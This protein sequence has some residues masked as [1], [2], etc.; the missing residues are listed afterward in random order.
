MAAELAR[1]SGFR[2]SARMALFT[3]TAI[4][5]VNYLDRYLVAGIVDPLKGEFDVG[6]A[7]I[8]LLT[9]VFLGVYMVAAPIFG[10]L[11]R[12]GS[13]TIWL[14]F[15]ILV[16]SIATIA[17]GLA[18]SFTQLLIARAVVGIGEAAYTAIGPALLSDHY[19]PVKRPVVL[20]IFYAAI[21]VG[22]ALSYIVAGLVSEAWGWRAVFF[23][24]GVPGLLLGTLC[25]FLVD[26]PR[27]QCDEGAPRS[28]T[29]TT[30]LISSVRAL[31]NNAAFLV[32][33]AGY[34][35]FTF[36]FGALAVWMPNYLESTRGWTRAD[37]TVTFGIVLVCSGI[38]GTLGGGLLVRRFGSGRRA[39]LALCALFLLIAAPA[40]AVSL[41]STQAWLVIT[42]LAIASTFSFA[43]QGPVNAVIVNAVDAQLR[44]LAVGLS[45]L[46]IHLFGDVP[47]PWLVGVISDSGAGMERAMSLIPLAMVVALLIWAIGVRKK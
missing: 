34:A 39:S 35:A 42:A 10:V 46:T 3:L 21:P 11:A 47:S 12:R 27:G 24:G 37:S 4:N 9:S 32:T 38:V 8:G 13:R 25:L 17:S 26:P 22:S 33:T 1:A 19:Q 40:A 14:G 2:G 29:S 15:A 23:A 16:W 6:D 20:S 44:P 41:Y 43:T 5:L 45:V 7:D 31:W 30:S 18:T 36:A 28:G